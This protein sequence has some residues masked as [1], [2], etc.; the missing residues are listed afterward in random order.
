MEAI[1]RFMNVSEAAEFLGVSP[2]S[3]RKWS[4]QDLL[5]VY[6]TPGGQRRYSPADLEAFLAS[7]RQEPANHAVPRYGRNVN[8]VTG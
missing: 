5:P 6:R 3:L 7:M 8:S 1:Q 4:D 2:A